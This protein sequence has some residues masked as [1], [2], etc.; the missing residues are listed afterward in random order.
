MWTVLL[1]YIL[2]HGRARVTRKVK[3]D[4]YASRSRTA[5]APPPVANVQTAQ[6]GWEKWGFKQRIKRQSDMHIQKHTTIHLA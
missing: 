3:I 5:F 1:V 2:G 4:L 6:R